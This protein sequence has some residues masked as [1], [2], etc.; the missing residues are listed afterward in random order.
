MKF[1]VLTTAQT[2]EWMQAIEPC[3]HD[4]YHLPQY[5]AVAERSGEGTALLFHFLEDGYSMALPLLIRTLDDVPG[6]A[7][8]AGWRDATSV[9]GYAGP[10]AS[11]AEIPERIV[12]NFQE[13]LQEHL[14]AM[15]V[16]TV[17]SRLHP[18]IAQQSLL[19]G[20]GEYQVLSQTVSID[21]TLPVEEQRRGYRTS[22]KTAINKVRRMGVTCVQDR[23]GVHLEEWMDIYY[24]TMRR[25]GAVESYFFPREYFRHLFH[26]LGDRF[27]LAVCL[28]EGKVVCGG[29]FIETG[30]I[31]QYHLGGTLNRALEFAPMKLLL[32]E[33]RLFANS[34]GLKVF[35]LGGGTTPHADNPLLHFKRGFSER[36]HDFPVW[37]WVLNVP[38]YQRLCRD[39]S[40]WC[41]ENGLEATSRGFFPAYRT[42]VVQRAVPP[43]LAAAT[44]IQEI[45]P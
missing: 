17:F 11:H 34:R 38:V 18:I 33:M 32:D 10:V 2:A 9:Y 1:E 39:R 20:M 25:V 40:Q 16:V 35:H 31:L 43:F 21:L 29:I 26:A 13:R 4:F 7:K 23:A 44:Q 15:N 5:H 37:R 22:L 14:E 30:E 42:P 36:L 41:D 6:I 12:R 45:H 27:C 8:G 28:L 19:K 3:A 24:E